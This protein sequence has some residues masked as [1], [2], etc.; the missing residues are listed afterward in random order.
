M[1]R[2][3]PI[4]KYQRVIEEELRVEELLLLLLIGELHVDERVLPV[5]PQ[6]IHAEV[7]LLLL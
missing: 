1:I 4:L 7:C 3:R 2:Y 5:E 6:L